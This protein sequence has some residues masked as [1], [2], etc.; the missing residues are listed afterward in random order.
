ML[1]SSDSSVTAVLAP[2]LSVRGARALGHC[3]RNGK[4]QACRPS[5]SGCAG[6]LDVQALMRFC[7]SSSHA[8]MHESWNW[9]QSRGLNLQQTGGCFWDRRSSCGL[10]RPCDSRTAG[11]GAPNSPTSSRRGD[12]GESRKPRFKGRGR[13]KFE[14]SNRWWVEA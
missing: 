13:V 14:H 9:P 6:H 1:N 11:K 8:H 2:M 5:S 12:R 7:G 4:I 10:D 3:S